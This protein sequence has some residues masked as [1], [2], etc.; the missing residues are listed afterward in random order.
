MVNETEN[1]SPR[2]LRDSCWQRV[3]LPTPLGP[4]RTSRTP[5]RTAPGWLPPLPAPD[6]RLLLKVLHLLPNP[7]HLSLHSQGDLGDF[8]A[9]G[10]GGDGVYLAVELLDKK[11]Q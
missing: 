11:I 9:L 4:E 10:L 2:T 8:Q 7:F 5:L 1:S 3:D 6:F